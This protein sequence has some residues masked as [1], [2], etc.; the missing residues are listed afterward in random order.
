[1]GPTR[2]TALELGVSNKT[3]GVEANFV[4]VDPDKQHRNVLPNAT[5]AD[6]SAFIG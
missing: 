3:V 2:D 4:P 5:F 1:M 6:I